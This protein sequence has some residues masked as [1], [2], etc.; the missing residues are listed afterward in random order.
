[1]ELSNE[2]TVGVP[3]EQA[4]KVLTDVPRIA[5]CL[6]GAQLQ[7]VEGEEYRGVVKVKVGPIVAQYK[8]KATFLDRDEAAH[9]VVLL[10]EGRETRGQGNAT[11]TIT[12]QLSEAGDVTTVTV[13]TD[14]KVTGKVAQIGR[15]VM[16]DVSGKLMGEFADNLQRT[17]LADETT[18]AAADEGLVDTPRPTDLADPTDGGGSTEETPDHGGVQAT[19]LDSSASNGRGPEVTPA[20][21]TTYDLPEPEPVDLLGTAG[22]PMLKRAAPAL[23]GLLLVVLIGLFLRRRRR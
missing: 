7:E 9:T 6:P 17:V 5:P 11:A 12:A 4:W 8:G 23:A 18:P 20:G 14:L 21:I 13:T 2:F 15:G 22:A 16:A 3:L 1:M 10:A 19:T